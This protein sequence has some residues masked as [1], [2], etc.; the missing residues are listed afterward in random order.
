MPAPLF[1]PADFGFFAEED[2]RFFL[3]NEKALSFALSKYQEKLT[4]ADARLREIMY[5]RDHSRDAEEQAFCTRWIPYHQD[6]CAN[7]AHRTDYLS[8]ALA[9]LTTGKL[10][11][12]TGECTSRE[13]HAARNLLKDPLNTTRGDWY[14]ND[15]NDDNDGYNGYDGYDDGYPPGC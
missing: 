1:D 15:D 6:L 9:L 10:P 12:D 13:L 7:A 2:F 11:L 14:D 5:V 3:Q 8:A 4:H